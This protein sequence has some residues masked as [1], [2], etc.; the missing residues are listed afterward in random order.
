M[1]INVTNNSDTFLNI[2][3]LNE[4]VPVSGTIDL[5]AAGHTLTDISTCDDLVDKISSGKL[6]VNNGENDLGVSDAIRYVTIHNVPYGPRDRSN[7]LRVHQT[8]R[9]IGLTWYWTGTG[10]DPEDVNNY[11]SGNKINTY[12]ISTGATLSGIIASDPNY[13]DFNCVENDTWI[14]EGYLTWQGGMCD[15]MSVEI[16]SAVPEWEWGSGTNFMEYNGLILPA[17]GVGNI[18]ITGDITAHNGGLVKMPL[19]DVG[20]RATAFWDA[21][22]DSTNKCYTNI[23]PAPTGDGQYN[24]FSS[25]WVFARFFNKIPILNNGSIHFRS[26]DVDQLGHGMRFKVTGYTNYMMGD[27]D[28]VAAAV[29]CMHRYY[30]R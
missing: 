18:D 7:K 21:D 4:I 22:W 25:E 12:H 9:T 20:D 27:H 24:I 11:G 6:I 8:A 5:V 2:Q 15:Q 3:G 29:L 17:A 30:T 23:T 14:Y 10:D 28:W 26:E 13:V 16:V 19:N 1:I